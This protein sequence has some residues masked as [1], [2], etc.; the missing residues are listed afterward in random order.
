MNGD[1]GMLSPST[2]ILVVDGDPNLLALVSKMLE[3]V[4]A[5][6]LTTETGTGALAILER[7]PLDLLILGLALPYFDGLEV[8]RA[9]REDSRFDQMPILVL[10]AKADSEMISRSFQLGADSYLT[11]PYLHN[12]LITRVRALMQQGRRPSGE[13]R[14][15]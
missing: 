6:P 5:K 3:R 2:L 7:E 11:K 8:L 9:I 12:T 13:S 1:T 10:S 14:T 15:E 4:G